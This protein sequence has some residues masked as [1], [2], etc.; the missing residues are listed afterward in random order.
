MKKYRFFSTW[1]L[2]GS[3]KVFD[4]SRWWP[5]TSSL[6]LQNG[7]RSSA[8]CTAACGKL[9][10]ACA[11][12]RVCVCLPGCIDL[13]GA[14]SQTWLPEWTEDKGRKQNGHSH[15]HALPATGCISRL[16]RHQLSPGADNE[17]SIRGESSFVP[18]QQGRRTKKRDLSILPLQEKK[19]RK[20]KKAP[21]AAILQLTALPL[22]LTVKIQ[23]KQAGTVW[24]RRLFVSL[25]VCFQ[26][27]MPFTPF[28]CHSFPLS[29][30]SRGHNAL[31]L[32]AELEPLYVQ[33]PQPPVSWSLIAL[34]LCTQR[35]SFQPFY[36]GAATHNHYLPF[37]YRINQHLAAPTNM[38][39]RLW[40]TDKREVLI[41]NTLVLQ[42]TNAA[43][44]F[45]PRRATWY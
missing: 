28:N 10:S 4:L 43:N 12:M 7:P 31:P 32:C 26:W 17:P 40:H 22:V 39:T 38:L 15:S 25:C 16:C 18:W 45:A 11:C 41:G 24:I 37:F 2:N 23:L 21:T 19:K 5:F 33:N 34:P 20:K 13:C 1:I 35:N 3:T 14:G 29:L 30:A 44:V 6:L 42:L 27:E 36:Y 8:G 9:Q